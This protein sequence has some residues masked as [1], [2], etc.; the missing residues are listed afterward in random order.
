MRAD[1]RHMAL[2]AAATHLKNVKN[3]DSGQTEG[4][5]LP[6]DVAIDF[7]QQSAPRKQFNAIVPIGILRLSALA[8]GLK[9]KPKIH[10]KS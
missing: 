4:A 8:E 3:A 6:I 7:K 2:F 9:H 5:T 1:S 10:E